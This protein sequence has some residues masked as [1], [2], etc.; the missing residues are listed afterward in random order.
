MPEKEI[1]GRAKTYMQN[2]DVT[3]TYMIDGN[4]NAQKDS[5]KCKMN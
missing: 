4:Q 3:W 1:M 5:F 2:T